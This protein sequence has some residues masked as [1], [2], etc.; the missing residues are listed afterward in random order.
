MHV[1]DICCKTDVKDNW[2]HSCGSKGDKV[3]LICNIMIICYPSLFYISIC[4]QVSNTLLLMP[5]RCFRFLSRTFVLTWWI[6]DCILNS[7]LYGAVR[8]HSR[9]FV[10]TYSI[11]DCTLNSTWYGAV[12]GHNRHAYLSISF[13]FVMIYLVKCNFGHTKMLFTCMTYTIKECHVH[14]NDQTRKK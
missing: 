5:P 4:M 2:G 7:T 10:L 9:T 12:R 11:T 6:T 3:W 14:I 1:A 13:T 8:G